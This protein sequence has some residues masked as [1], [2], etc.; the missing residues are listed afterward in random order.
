MDEHIGQQLAKATV[1]SRP[2]LPWVGGWR[3]WIAEAMQSGERILYWKLRRPEMNTQL[4]YR[5]TCFLLTIACALCPPQFVYGSGDLDAILFKSGHP[6]TGES[7][8][9]A[10]ADPTS[11]QLEFL[12]A[13]AEALRHTP[14]IAVEVMGFA[15]SHECTVSDCYHLSLRRAKCVCEWLVAHGVPAFKLKGPT[16][17]GSGWPID[18]S[19]TEEGRQYNRRVQLDFV[20][21]NQ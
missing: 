6:L 20:S 14:E 3:P 5:A 8:L 1:V 15:D 7:L 2:Y 10:L 16:G 12:E 17:N 4:S 11:T 19:G 21:P 18:R 9:D 13:N